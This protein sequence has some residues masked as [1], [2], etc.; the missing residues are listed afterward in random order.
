MLLP[1][2]GLAVAEKILSEALC[3]KPREISRFTTGYCHRVYYINTKSDEYVLRLTNKENEKYWKGSVKWLPQLAELEIPVPKILKYGYYEGV[4]YTLLSYLP[5]NDLGEVYHTLSDC[6]KRKIAKELS[7]IQVKTAKLPASGFYGYPC[8]KGN[9]FATWMEYL[10]SLINRSFERI[11]QNGI[12]KTN[13][14]E[15]VR[16]L[17]YSLEEY[18]LQVS[19]TAFLDDISTKNVRIHEGKFA[20]IVDVDEICYGDRLLVVALTNM[21]L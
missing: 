17:M 21:A 18:F 11:T 12:F 15:E 7:A 5:A 14:C 9:F 16:A 20:G 19:P 8:S 4:F 6:Q 1:D 3:I 13:V 2:A 10:S